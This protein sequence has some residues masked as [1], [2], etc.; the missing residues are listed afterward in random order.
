LS[1]TLGNPTLR[2]VTEGVGPHVGQTIT[3]A[4]SPLAEAAMALILVHGR[5]GS[6]DEML[7]LAE[8]VAPAGTAYL[9]PQAA[10]HTWY[11][12]RFIEPVSVNEPYLGSALS[13]LGALVDRVVAGGVPRER[14]GLLG[15]SQG[16]CLALEFARRQGR[17]FGAVIGFSGGLIGE[18]VPP[19][20]PD[21]GRFDAMPVFLGCSERDPHIPIARVQ[22]TDAVMRALGAKVITRIYPGSNHGINEDEAGVARQILSWIAEAPL[23]PGRTRSI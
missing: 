15:F 23:A 20:A 7:G 6:A 19:A 1:Q 8:L 21:D 22:E 2:D 13:V 9:A 10:G 4:G 17:R 18:T 5:G 16:A 14:I 3:T 11:P 12:H